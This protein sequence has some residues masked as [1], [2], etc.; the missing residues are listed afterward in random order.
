V[1]DYKF[2]FGLGYDFA[3]LVGSSNM[4]SCWLYLAPCITW[5][6]WEWCI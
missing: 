1:K 5:Y 2:C 4:A 6:E 3:M